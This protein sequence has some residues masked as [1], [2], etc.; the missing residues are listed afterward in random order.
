M[1]GGTAAAPAVKEIMQYA[2]Q[3]LEIAP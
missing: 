3:R 2:L 1:F